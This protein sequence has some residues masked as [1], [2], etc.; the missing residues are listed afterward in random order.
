MISN[1]LKKFIEELK[2]YEEKQNTDPYEKY[3]FGE[4]ATLVSYLYIIDN[5]KGK[6][7]EI[8]SELDEFSEDYPQH[9]YI[10]KA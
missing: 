5:Q 6:K 10:Y 9:H 3:Q 7:I 4:C 1:R 8:N 2:K